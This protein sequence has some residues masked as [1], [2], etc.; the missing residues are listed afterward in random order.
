MNLG[1]RTA[2]TGCPHMCFSTYRPTRFSRGLQAL[3]TASLPA[4][5]RTRRTKDRDCEPRGRGIHQGSGRLSTLAGEVLRRD[6]S[7]PRL[8]RRLERIADR[9]RVRCVQV[10]AGPPTRTCTRRRKR[11]VR[12]GRRC[13]PLASACHSG[14]DREKV[15]KYRIARLVLR[16]H[17]RS[18]RGL[19]AST[20]C[21]PGL[22]SRTRCLRC[23][24]CG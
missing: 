24:K 10:P 3:D 5:H 9:Q 7:Q 18:A 6:S 19:P 14:Q 23:R 13:S 17:Y 12:Q 22:W 11:L 20:S 1:R 8:A 15:C 16:W 4:E 21:V 2:G